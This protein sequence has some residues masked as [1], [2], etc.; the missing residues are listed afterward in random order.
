V[1]TL[2]KL[3]KALNANQYPGQIALSLTLGMLLGLTPLFS[4]HT[5]LT[6]LLIFLLRVNFSALLVAWTIFTGLAYVFDPLFHQFG[7]WVLSHPGLVELWTQWY[8]QPF[9]RFINFNNTLVMGSVIVAYCFA[10]VFFVFSW[11]LVRVYRK[12]F[13]VWVNKFKVVQLLKA[14]DKAALISGVVK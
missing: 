4:P 10:P 13:L 2:L 12:R 11:V 14:S 8:N 7:V 1:G 9:W 6:L 5:L 3:F